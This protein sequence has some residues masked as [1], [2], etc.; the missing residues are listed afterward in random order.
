LF[1]NAG[2]AR[3]CA[4]AKCSEALWDQTF[5][6]NVKGPYFQIQALLPL[7]N[8]G[9]AIVINGSINAHLGVPGSSVY[10]ASKA[11]LISLART[12]SAELLP[13]GVRVNVISPGPV[14]TRMH[15][16]DEAHRKAI[17]AQVPLGRLGTADEIAATVLHLSATKSAFIVGSEIIADGGMSRL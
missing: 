2:V 13:H 8:H 3:F 16:A 5:D 9:A 17:A 1:I 10:A 15:G 4:F 6:I 12:L 14:A 7:F 11:A